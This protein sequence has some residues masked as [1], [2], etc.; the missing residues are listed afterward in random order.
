VVLYPNYRGSIGRDEAF[1]RGDHGDLMGA[2]FADIVA[3]IDALAARG[4][5]D[6]ERVG[7]A[8]TSYGGY[9][10]AWAVTAH[11]RRFAA[12]IECAGITN[13]LSMQGT[14]DIPE[15]NAL[16]HWNRPF[17][18]NMDLYWDRSPLAHVS[19]CRTPLLILHGDKDARVPV[20]QA[21][22]LYTALRLLGREVEFVHY[23]REE[24]GL[25]EAAHQLD[26]L[27]RSLAWFDRYLKQAPGGVTS[28]R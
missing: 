28:R 21:H 1:E 2:E 22:E 14:S 18:E 19:Q 16:V 5:V 20:T 26:M 10:T 9:T 11:S 3:G 24:H 25:K 13:W 6:P 15:E 27:N 17:Y 7:I 23:P 12:G 4:M 8:G